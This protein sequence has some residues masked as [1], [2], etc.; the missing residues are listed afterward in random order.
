MLNQFVVNVYFGIFSL[1]LLLLA[2][3]EY[4]YCFKVNICLFIATDFLFFI[5]W[6]NILCFFAT[7]IMGAVPVNDLGV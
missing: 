2:V 5:K 1:P 4:D 7:V 3:N 6:Q